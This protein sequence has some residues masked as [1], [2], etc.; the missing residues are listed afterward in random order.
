[1]TAEQR[2]PNVRRLV[3]ELVDAAPAPPPF[4]SGAV[5]V[6]V[7]EPAAVRARRPR[8]WIV[9]ALAVVIVA[10]TVG[11][12]VIA[13]RSP[14][15]HPLAAPRS[16]TVAY[17]DSRGLV[18]RSATGAER[19]VVSGSVS[20]P[21]WSPSGTWVAYRDGDAVVR[22]V[23][24][25]G[26]TSFLV[27]RAGTYTWSPT[28]D[29][30]AV[31]DQAGVHVWT[32]GELPPHA[33]TVDP[34]VGGVDPTVQSFAWSR[35][36]TSLAIA[37]E[38]RDRTGPGAPSDSLWL[39]TGVCRPGTP[40]VCAQ[41]REL[42][43]IPYTPGQNDYPLLV[44]GFGFDNSQVLFWADSIGS[45]SIE[46]DGLPLKA[47]PIDGGSG[48][49]IATTIVR[50]SWVQPSPDGAQLLVV[51]SRGRMV[52]DPREV[53]VCTAPDACRALAPAPDVQTL[54]PAWSPDGRE[55]AFVRED[56]ASYTPPITNGT[57]DWKTKYRNRKLWIA[58][59]DGSHAHELTAAGAG[60]ADPQFAPDGKSIAFVRDAQVWQLDLATGK[61]ELL[62]GSLR[63]GPKC[64]FDDCLPDIAPYEATN[65]WSSYY[66]VKFADSSH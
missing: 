13:R 48:K 26:G 7:T 64:T 41:P 28:L 11:A 49:T 63:T 4:P 45:S 52:T 16:A 44:T 55:I 15:Q 18:V 2:D 25:D 35:G 10:G 20:G 14:T 21:R 58:N 30:L 1:M 57:V 47:V 66:A 53:D 54:D 40:A 39:A 32:F 59:A 24:G 33:V 43:R 50:D 23:S 61:V 3:F 62:S 51:R 37:M 17:V 27:G 46:M 6:A 31:S 36:G 42:T 19:V 22:V 34:A 60:I 56:H 8:A 9:A 5:A 29:A 65:L 38:H 12:V